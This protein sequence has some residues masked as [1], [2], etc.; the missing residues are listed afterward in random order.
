MGSERM[1]ALVDTGCTYNLIDKSFARKCVQAYDDTFEE[2][3]IAPLILGDGI[4]PLKPIGVLRCE[5]ESLRN[6]NDFGFMRTTSYLSFKG[7]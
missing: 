4:T 6:E 2:M 3:D 7:T 1:L 5:H